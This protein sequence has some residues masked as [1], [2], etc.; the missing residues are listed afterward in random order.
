MMCSACYVREAESNDRR[1]VECR[2]EYQRIYYH[3]SIKTQAKVNLAWMIET[4][5]A[6]AG[7]ARWHKFLEDEKRIQKELDILASMGYDA[8]IDSTTADEIL[9]VTK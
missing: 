9:G 1:C 5:G 6:Q 8:D 7:Q 3:T 2:R 4:Y